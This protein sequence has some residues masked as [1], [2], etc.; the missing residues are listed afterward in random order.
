MLKTERC[1]AYDNLDGVCFAKYNNYVETIC[2]VL[3]A[4][5]LAS[6]QPTISETTTKER[7]FRGYT[8][9]REFLFLLNVLAP[10]ELYGHIK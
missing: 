4:P 5:R 3:R 7:R 8:A 10:M 9:E 6:E 2:F 1:N